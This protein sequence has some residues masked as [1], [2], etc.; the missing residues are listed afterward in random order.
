MNAGVASPLASEG[1]RKHRFIGFTSIPWP[2]GSGTRT[3]QLHGSNCGMMRTM[4][5][6]TMLPLGASPYQRA[7]A[8]DAYLMDFSRS[9]MPR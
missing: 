5:H 3:D 1:R 2:P 6:D 7:L 9:L 4:Q 8:R